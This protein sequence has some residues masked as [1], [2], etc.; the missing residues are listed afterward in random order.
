MPWIWDAENKQEKGKYPFGSIE[1]KACEVDPK[2][3]AVLNKIIAAT[4]AKVV[5]SSVWRLNYTEEQLQQILE[6]HGFIGEVIGLTPRCYPLETGKGG[7]SERCD[8][9]QFFMDSLPEPVE[10]FVIL[11]DES[12]MGHLQRFLVKTDMFVGLRDEHA[13]AAIKILCPELESEV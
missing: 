2:A 1:Y 7:W 11:D 8:E 4:D 5:V 6:V 10:S 3:V 13:D 12:N 9:I